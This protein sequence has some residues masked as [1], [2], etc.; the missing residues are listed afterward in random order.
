MLL[1]S[2]V[3]LLRFHFSLFLM[4]VYWFALSQVVNK[5]WGKAIL[6]FFIFHI[7]VYP[8]SNGYNSY[9]DKDLGSIGGLQT[10]PQPSRQLFYVT[11]CMD[12]LAVGLSLLVGLYF[13]AG[14]ILYILASRAYSYRGIR[15]KRY[16][17]TGYL[18]VILCQGA[19]V[20]ALVFSGSHANQHF[21]IPIAPLIGSSLLIGAFYPLA[22]V[23][24]H[25]A[26]LDDGVKTISWLLGY[27]G[28][29]V[30][31]ALLYCLA[32]GTLAFYFFSSL[33]VKEFFVWA[34]CMLPVL[35]Y[36]FVW[37]VGVWKDV[38]AA[39][40]V[41]TMRMIV[42]ASFFSNTSFI[43]ILIMQYQLS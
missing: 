38:K 13:A 2:T 16:P 23:Y 41:N 28:T 24:Q 43:V 27:K 5:D 10:P 39:N 14:I 6:I 32:F 12:I 17:I 34:T 25:K 37:A 18:T 26:D 31:T 29:F 1:R 9:M 20:F 3:Q 42:L 35:V 40:F 33:E 30:F 8:A 15:L 4:P 19:L 7:L 11:L 21:G 22:Q 36:F